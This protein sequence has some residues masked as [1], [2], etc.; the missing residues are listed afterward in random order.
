MKTFLSI[1]SGPGIGMA[2]VERFA[3]EGY[4]S[5]ITSR[6][7]AAL[8]D[9]ASALAAKGYQV[10]TRA[11]NPGDIESVAA[12][13]REVEA[14]FHAIDILH[15]NSA[16]MHASTIEQP[17]ESLMADLIVNLGAA[18]VAV[19]QVAPAMLERGSGSIL[20]TGGAYSITPNP[21]YL[22][23]GIGKAGIRNL[24]QA[25]FDPFRDRGVHIAT[26]NVAALVAAGSDDA[27]GV[28]DVFWGLHNTPPAAW[29]SEVTYSG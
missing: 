1:G 18:L 21:D 14:E 9:R 13:V 26:V 29:T 19:Q 12:L 2:T 11:V 24:V 5:V 3:R 4:R 6:D 27:H 8:E 28:A 25:L 7:T 23:I 17:A 10:E 15:F 20:L 22:M 16:A